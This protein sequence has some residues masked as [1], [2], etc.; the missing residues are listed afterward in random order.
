MFTNFLERNYDSISKKVA[1]LKSKLE[2]SSD[3][4]NLIKLKILTKDKTHV[5]TKERPI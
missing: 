2:I 4:D 3:P 1:R 5:S